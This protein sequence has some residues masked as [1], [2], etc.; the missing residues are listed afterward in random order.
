[1]QLYFIQ[2]IAEPV[3]CQVNLDNEES[4]HCVK[5]LRMRS[6]DTIHLTDGNGNL[7]EGRLLLSDTKK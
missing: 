2:P 4:F 1:M 7:Y 3:P 6:G 5:V